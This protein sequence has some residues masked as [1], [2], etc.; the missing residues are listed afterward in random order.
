[1]TTLQTINGLAEVAENYGVL[2]V[3]QFG[4][5]HDGQTAY[6]H[7]AEALE[8]YRTTGGKVVVLSNSAK[9]G[10]DN[11]ERLK[12][13]G[14]DERHFD[15][16]VT[17][18][19]A[20]QAAMRSGSLGP[21][22]QAGGKIHISGKLGADYGFSSFGFTTAWPDDADGIILAACQEP[23][24]NWRQQIRDLLGAARR[25][26]TIAVCNPDLEML[27][28]KGVRPSAGAVLRTFG[29]PH[30]DIY[31]T[32][33]AAAGNPPPSAVLAI[34]DSPEHDLQGA[35]N[36]ALDGALVRTGIMISQDDAALLPR[37]PKR[38]DRP[39]LSLAELRW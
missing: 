36:A 6:P 4:T 34:G 38:A 19:D 8:R 39:W 29:K 5:L 20:A 16:V 22:F 1:M 11:R 25:G 33:L 7:A 18:G 37:L 14:F 32:A 2:L 28:P 27:T 9:S 30:I 15:A 10:E 35:A 31:R 12:G 3:D 21:A 13:F 24:R 17:S 23:D 26:V